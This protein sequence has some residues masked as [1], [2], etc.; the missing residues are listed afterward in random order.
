MIDFSCPRNLNCRD[1]MNWVMKITIRSST[2]WIQK[3]VLA[4]PPRA[5][6][7]SLLTA[8]PAVGS[9]WTSTSSILCQ[10]RLGGLPLR[11]EGHE[12]C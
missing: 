11:Y 10:P 1:G 2:G 12:A 7:L 8:S 3:A 5:V 9:S 4:A 6:P